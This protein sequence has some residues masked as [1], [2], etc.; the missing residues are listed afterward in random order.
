[1]AEQVLEKR[2]EIYWAKVP[3]KTRR[4]AVEKAISSR[5]CDTDSILTAGPSVGDTKK[6][7]AIE[8]HQA[9]LSRLKYPC[10]LC[11]SAR[12]SGVYTQCSS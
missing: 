8:E 11:V 2:E 5:C 4:Q 1:M 10:Q 3:E 7:R 6:K 12:L 9:A